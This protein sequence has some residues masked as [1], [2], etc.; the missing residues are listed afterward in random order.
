MSEKKSSSI[1]EKVFGLFIISL[2][3]IGLYKLYID[4]FT[5]SSPV[6]K[7]EI[8]G[9]KEVL[10]KTEKSKLTKLWRND[11]L[12]MTK[13]GLKPSEFDSI[14]NLKVYML[15]KNLHFLLDDLKAPLKSQKDGHYTL[16][17]SFISHF[18]EEQ[19]KNVLIIQYNFI[20]NETGNMVLETSR[21]ITLEDDFLK[22]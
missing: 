21:Q 2:G 13:K 11:F 8:S 5:P 12:D 15:D 18:S 1:V 16:E 20:E 19:N 14:S 4:D 17:T 6:K 10:I 7:K 22:E 9:D 3:L